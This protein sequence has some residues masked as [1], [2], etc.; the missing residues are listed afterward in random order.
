MKTIGKIVFEI[1]SDDKDWYSKVKPV[2]LS[3]NALDYLKLGLLTAEVQ[4]F[5]RDQVIVLNA[6]EDGKLKALAEK[7]FHQDDK[8]KIR[9]PL[10]DTEKYQQPL[11]FNVKGTQTGRVSGV[12]SNITEVPREKGDTS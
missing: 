1:L 2:V 5:I 4:K 7:L 11:P 9:N 3:Q 10:P 8:G 6:D 12:K